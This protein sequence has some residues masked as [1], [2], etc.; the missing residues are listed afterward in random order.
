MPSGRY[1]TTLTGISSTSSSYPTYFPDTSIRPFSVSVSA[2]VNS[3]SVAYTINHTLDYTG[4]S[5]F[6]STAATWFPSSGIT[7]ATTNAFTAYTFPVT[8]IQLAST[9]GSSAGTVTVT[10]VQAG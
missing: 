2:A 3:T 7:A 6:V 1:T 4:S 8:A 5:A 9:A 10:I